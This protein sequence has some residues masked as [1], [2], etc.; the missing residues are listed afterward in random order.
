VPSLAQLAAFGFVFTRIVPVTTD[1]FLVFLFAGIIAWNWFA[2]ALLI[3]AGSMLRRDLVLRPGFQTWLLPV[4]ACVVAF[5]DYLLALPVLLATAAASIG[6]GTAYAILPLLLAMQFVLTLGIAMILAPL[7]VLFRDIGHLVGV[8]LLLGFFLT[9]V[10]YSIDH[11]PH[12]FSAMYEL[13]P[14][15]QIITAERTVLID[16]ALPPLVPMAL[17]ALAAAAILGLGVLTFRRLRDGLADHV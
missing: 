14:V 1:H 4:V 2:A 17:T 3:G 12:R 8:A 10:F 13:N 7:N 6:V 16:N 9:P 5:V 15:A 11:V